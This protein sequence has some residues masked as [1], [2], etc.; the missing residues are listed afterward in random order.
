MQI[1]KTLQADEKLQTFNMLRLG[2]QN[3]PS[4]YNG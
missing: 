2:F 1:T 3:F 4:G